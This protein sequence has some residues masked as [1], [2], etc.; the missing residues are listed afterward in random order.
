MYMCVYIY[1]YIYI[2]VP[3]G[4]STVQIHYQNFPTHLH[5]YIPCMTYFLGRCT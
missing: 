5:Y 1:I 4:D 2:Y 3:R